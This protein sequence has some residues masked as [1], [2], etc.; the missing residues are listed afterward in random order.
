V[1]ETFHPGALLGSSFALDNHVR[2]RLRL[3]RGSDVPL[4]RALVARQGTR[5]EDLEMARLVHFDPRRRAVLCAT[6][7]I[8]ST[9]TLVG[10]GAVELDGTGEPELVIVDA[11]YAEP[12]SQLLAAA[13]AARVAVAVASR[14]A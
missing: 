8:D 11:A 2:V 6:A 5:P 1:A 4:I 3:A 14:A 9:E 7:L 12:L 10:V 13:L